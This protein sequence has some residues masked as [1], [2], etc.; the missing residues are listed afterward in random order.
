[1]CI[2]A[3]V[4][5]HSSSAC[6][7]PFMNSTCPTAVTSLTLAATTRARRTIFSSCC[8]VT[9][10]LMMT[11]FATRLQR[12]ETTDGGGGGARKDQERASCS[13]KRVRALSHLRKPQGRHGFVC[14]GGSTAACCDHCCLAVA[15]QRLAQQEREAARRVSIGCI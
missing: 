10:V 7:R 4:G 2:K 11:S 8:R 5:T 6:V 9:R 15:A 1:M 3:M 13:S 14:I 12:Y